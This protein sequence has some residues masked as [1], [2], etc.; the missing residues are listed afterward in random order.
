MTKTTITIATRE[1]PLAL[2][3]ANWVKSRLEK[4]HPHLVVK[5]LGLTTTADA[6]LDIPLADV[7][8][9]GLFVKE[10]EE[11]LLQGHA[12]IAVHSMKDV[13]MEFPEGLYLPV[14][15]ERE[16][17]HDVLVTNEN[18]NLK[19]LPKDALIGTSSFRRQSQLKALRPDL[20]VAP[21]RGNV[22]TRLSKLDEGKYTAIILAAAGLIRLDL[23][24]RIR[25]FL[26]FDESLPA[27]GQGV[28]GIECREN[29]DAIIKLISSLNHTE[30]ALCVTAERALCKRLGGGC[31]APIAAFAE[32]KENK[33]Y[34]RGLVGRIDGTLILRAE[35]IAPLT[36]AVA[37]GNH[38]AQQLIDQGAEEMLKCLPK[39]N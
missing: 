18:K 29:D 4:L 38:I 36:D 24:S 35:G 20:N 16:N 10:L 3:Q 27:A 11:A 14:M 9:K 5:L 37:L 33:I 28:L 25:S 6:L 19:T 30:S 15:C 23:Q 21:L 1:S 12:D 32:I 34:L 13:P 22:Q 8:G 26:S 7:G 39:K 2:W 31:H 17:P